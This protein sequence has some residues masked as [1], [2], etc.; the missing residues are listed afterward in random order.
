MPAHWHGRTF[1]NGLNFQLNNYKDASFFIL[2]AQKKHKNCSVG[3][4]HTNCIR[5]GGVQHVPWECQSSSKYLVNFLKN[6]LLR[7]FMFKKTFIDRK[8]ALCWGL[9]CCKFWHKNFNI[10]CN[11]VSATCIT[12]RHPWLTN[13]GYRPWKTYQSIS[14]LKE[15][16]ANFN[17]LCAIPVQ[18]LHPEPIPLICRQNSKFCVFRWTFFGLL[19]KQLIV[20]PHFCITA[21]MDTGRKEVNRFLSLGSWENPF[22]KFRSNCKMR[23]CWSHRNKIC[24]PISHLKS[25]RHIFWCSV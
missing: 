4:I 10:Y 17:Q 23:R 19:F 18:N 7:Y 13:N 3:L 12:Y 25:F 8:A 15:Y 11:W 2:D 20:P 21:S 14:N 24:Y 1:W 9:H 16:C 6:V 22:T 5:E